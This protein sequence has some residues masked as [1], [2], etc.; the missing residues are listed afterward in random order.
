MVRAAVLPA[1]LRGRVALLLLVTAAIAVREAPGWQNAAWGNDFGI[2]L[3]ITERMLDTGELFPAYDGWGTSYQFFP[4]FYLVSAAAHVLTGADLVWLMPKVAGI[5]GGLGVLFFYLFVA[6]SSRARPPHRGAPR[7][8]GVPLRLPALAEDGEA[9]PPRARRSGPDPVPPPHDLLPHP[10]RGGHGPRRASPREGGAGGRSAGTSCS[11]PSSP[12]R[13]SPTGAPWRPPSRTRSGTRPD[14]PSLRCSPSPSPSLRRPRGWPAAWP[15]AW[16]AS[17][18]G[19]PASLL[20]ARSP[21]PS[22]PGASRSSPPSSSRAPP[23]PPPPRS[24]PSPPC[25]RSSSPRSPRPASSVTCA[26]A[27]DPRSSG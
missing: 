19:S 11:S 9:R 10:L 20:P 17:S 4:T 23:A 13:R 2:Y 22:W 21:S 5:L 24:R 15:R 8:R 14:S 3:G 16:G 26:P 7:P 25:P 1:T 27:P 12:R 6:G 18:S